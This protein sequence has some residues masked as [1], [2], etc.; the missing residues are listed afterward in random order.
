MPGHSTG[1]YQTPNARR[2]TS[3]KKFPDKFD[4]EQIRQEVQS[5]K[6]LETRYTHRKR[7]SRQVTESAKKDTSLEANNAASSKSGQVETNTVDQIL[8]HLN[9]EFS[10]ILH[11]EEFTNIATILAHIECLL[12]EKDSRVR[13]IKMINFE[14]LFN[15]AL[16][17]DTLH[18]LSQLTIKSIASRIKRKKLTL[19]QIRKLKNELRQKLNRMKSARRQEQVEKNL[20]ERNRVVNLS[21]RITEVRTLDSTAETS[22]IWW[23]GSTSNRSTTLAAGPQVRLFPIRVFSREM[24]NWEFAGKT[25]N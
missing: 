8:E 12:S 24:M 6:V 9:L 10:E 2:P 20:R 22:V 25:G 17:E 14:L 15:E 3:C 4:M 23:Q 5:W 19:F 21:S 11:D 7:S 13:E 18:F 1:Q 16:N